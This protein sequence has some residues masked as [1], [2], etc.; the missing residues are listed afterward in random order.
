[1]K[2]MIPAL[3][4]AAVAALAPSVA[5]ADDKGSSRG[6]VD[7]PEWVDLQ[8]S[9]D[10]PIRGGARRSVIEDSWNVRPIGLR[11]QYFQPGNDLQ[12]SEAYAFCQ[13]S[14]ML[15]ILVYRKTSGAWQMALKG[16]FV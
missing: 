8:V 11:N 1:M 10:D 15:I 13:N 12:Y 6:C 9:L 3:A 7:T 16:A 2:K 5:H 14:E 4:L